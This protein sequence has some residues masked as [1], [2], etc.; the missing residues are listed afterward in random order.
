MENIKKAI[1]S[2]E[3]PNSIHF[4][5]S[6]GERVATIFFNSEGYLDSSSVEVCPNCGA[7]VDEDDIPEEE[8][9]IAL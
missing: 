3:A 6:C 2:K 1:L 5:C 4:K 8:I 9:N 7:I